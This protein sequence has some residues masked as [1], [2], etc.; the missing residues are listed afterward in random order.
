[1][2]SHLA[3]VDKFW[4]L[5]SRGLFNGPG[6]AGPRFFRDVKLVGRLPKPESSSWTALRIS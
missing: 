6:A 4:M 1:M 5:Q 2:L 3:A